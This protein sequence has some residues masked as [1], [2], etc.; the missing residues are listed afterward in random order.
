M[1]KIMPGLPDGEN[2]K[3]FVVHGRRVPIQTKEV[4]LLKICSKTHP[5]RVGHYDKHH[6]RILLIMN[7][8]PNT[9]HSFGYPSTLMHTHLS[10][11]REPKKWATELTQAEVCNIMIH[12]V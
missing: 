7:E 5:S 9:C 4:S 12:L 11:G 8:I 1:V 10:Y 2:G 6:S 3:N